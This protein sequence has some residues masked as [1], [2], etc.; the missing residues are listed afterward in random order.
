LASLVLVIFMVCIVFCMV[1]F[2]LPNCIADVGGVI[3]LGLFFMYGF[4]QCCNRLL[5]CF[6][7]CSLLD[8]SSDE[9]SCNERKL[10]TY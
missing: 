8:Q 10:A 7:D 2:A 9:I 5:T 3:W 1:T 6:Y 4:L